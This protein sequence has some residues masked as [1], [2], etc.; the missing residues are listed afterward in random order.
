MEQKI[1]CGVGKVPKGYRLGT[2]EEC[3]KLGQVRLYGINKINPMILK[4]INEESGNSISKKNLFEKKILL[5]VKIKKLIKEM[6]SIQDNELKE[7]LKND[8]KELI[9]EIKEI[10]VKLKELS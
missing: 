1:Y 5:D 8:A 4:N 3:M 7:K 6:N 9:A 10:N 2:M